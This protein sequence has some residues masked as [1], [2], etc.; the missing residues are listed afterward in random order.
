MTV[1]HLFVS[2]IT[3]GADTTLVRPSNWNDD[4]SIVTSLLPD[5]DDGASLGSISKQWSDLFLATGAVLNFNNG[6][7][8]LTQATSKLTLGGSGATGTNL[9]LAAGGTSLPPLLFTSGTT[10]TIA[11][12][13]E[14]EYDS[15]VFMSTPTTGARGINLSTMY[16]IVEAGGFA[17]ATGA[18]VQS[19]F[20]TTKD[21]WT[22]NAS[23]TYYVEGTYNITKSTNAV[24]TAIAFALAGGASITSMALNVIS[25]V[26][27]ANT[28]VTANNS[29]YVTQVAS[30]V[31]TI[32]TASPTCIRFQGIIR[33]N[34]G[35]TV[36]PQINFSGTAAGTPT[37]AVNSYIMFTPIGTNTQNTMGNVA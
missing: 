19:A 34:G 26:S 21:V 30:T 14:M 35:G 12:A 20:P 5:A 16:A 15:V 17:L 11:T 4:H 13:G 9:T 27:T 29:T 10:T 1:K 6:N 7:L 37:M 33:M 23:T 24:T 36:T 31:V 25:Y 28:T 18:G 8:T 3:D 32:S 22:L 2:G